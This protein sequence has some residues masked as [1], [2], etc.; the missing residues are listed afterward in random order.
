MTKKN[1]EGIQPLYRNKTWNINER[2]KNKRDKRK[3]WFRKNGSEAVFFLDATP[4]EELA[5]MCREAFKSQGLK[6]KVIE[7]T[8]TTMK[9]SLVKSNPFKKNGCNKSTCKL[10]KTGN[11]INKRNNI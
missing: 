4:N 1:D 3:H 5:N 8:G 10:C 9:K 7:R 2:T 11:E 6:I